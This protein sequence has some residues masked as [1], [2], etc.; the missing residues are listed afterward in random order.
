[1]FL[2]RKPKSFFFWKEGFYLWGLNAQHRFAVADFHLSTNFGAWKKRC[3]CTITPTFQDAHFDVPSHNAVRRE[4]N[5]LAY[6]L[7]L[8]S[9]EET[10][11]EKIEKTCCQ[12]HK[13]HL[14]VILFILFPSIIG[15][16]FLDKK[17][18]NKH[19]FMTHTL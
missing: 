17:L 18:T 7:T 6:F 10:P 13:E 16:K 12:D 9:R 15:S 5:G 19:N 2:Q 14:S 1:M 3:N 11:E 8:Q 4:R